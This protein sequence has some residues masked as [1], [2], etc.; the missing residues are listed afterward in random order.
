MARIIAP[1][2][3]EGTL[4]DTNFY[5]DQGKVNRAR[6]KAESSM[7]TKKFKTLPSYHNARMQNLEL[8]HC[9]KISQT[10]QRIVVAFNKNAKD[11]SFA[12]RANAIFLHM[13]KE[14]QN[15]ERGY[16]LVTE[17][18]KSKYGRE[19]LRGFESNKLRPLH[20][21]LVNKKWTLNDHLF[22]FPECTMETDIDWPEDATHITF[23]LAVANWN[24]ETLHF[25]TNYAE[26]QFFS[27]TST[28]Q[29][30]TITGTPPTDQDLHLTFLFIGFS[31]QQGS[32]HL[33]L[34]RKNNTAT[35]IEH[36]YF[37]KHTYESATD[38]DETPTKNLAPPF[39]FT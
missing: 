39:S 7:T 30:I 28:P 37:P 32:R 23:N 8:T 9:S 3:I 5:I 25:T 27:K 4:H 17:G 11:G 16:R 12:G 10:F 29:D 24:I 34:H 13:V 15:N 35:L 21:V 33:P 38:P 31:K 26:A 1:F 6:V 14:D 22:H 2:K 19:H 36:H 20:K 18:I